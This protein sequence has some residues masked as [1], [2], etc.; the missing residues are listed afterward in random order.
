MA[1]QPT[2][3]CPFPIMGALI[4]LQ[5][6]ASSQV[7]LTVVFCFSAHGTLLPSPSGCLYTA[8]PSPL[9][10]TDLWSLSLSVQP[11]PS[12]QVVSGG[13]GTKGLCGSLSGLKRAQQLCP[14]QSSCCAFLH[15]FEVPLSWL[16]SPSVRWLLSV[17]VPFLF[18]G[19]LSG[20][21]VPS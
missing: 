17:W 13:S 10:R 3:S 18:P 15:D 7:P 16:I 6:Q 12:S 2:S 8:S 21:L 14:L 19:S 4:L 5:A 1:V 11:C 9:L 20:V